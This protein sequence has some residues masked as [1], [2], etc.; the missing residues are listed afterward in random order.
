MNKSVGFI[1][2]LPVS[3]VSPWIDRQTDKQIDKQ[4]R[5]T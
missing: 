3:C 1:G 4:K 5:D 2:H